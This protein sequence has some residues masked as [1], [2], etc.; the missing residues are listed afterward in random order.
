MSFLSCTHG[1]LASSMVDQFTKGQLF[2]DIWQRGE[3]KMALNQ[4]KS[5]RKRVQERVEI[6]GN[7]RKS[8]FSKNVRKTA[9]KRE[10]QKNKTTFTLTTLKVVRV[11]VV[12]FF[13][14]S[15][16]YGVFRTFFENTDFLEFPEIFSLKKT[17]EKTP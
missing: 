16:F 9:L 4:K 5:A 14:F 13:R 8:I 15:H 1:P 11:K 2:S 7:S 6:P 10:F 17:S 12:L 3:L